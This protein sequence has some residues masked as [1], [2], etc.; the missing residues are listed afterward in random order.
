MVVLHFLVLLIFDVEFADLGGFRVE[1]GSLFEELV[2]AGL[3]DGLLE[4]VKLT[5]VVFTLFS[6]ISG[7]V[8]TFLIA[9][10]LVYLVSLNIL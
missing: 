7:R 2:G 1:V 9:S 5:V 6:S 3:I 8:E 4:L 10:L